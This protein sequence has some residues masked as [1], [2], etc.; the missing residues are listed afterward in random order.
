MTLFTRTTAWVEYTGSRLAAA[1][2]DEKSTVDTLERH[3]ALSAVRNA[4][5]KT[6]TAARARAYEDPEYL[7]AQEA[8]TR[9]YAYRK[10][11]QA[12]HDSAERKNTLLSRELTRR[13]GRG[14]RE[15]R[16]GRMSA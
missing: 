2:V 9:A 10:L 8:K 1:E 16:A 12:V 3:K 5:E 7:E 6:V 15:A 11:L 13:V 4:S 14:D